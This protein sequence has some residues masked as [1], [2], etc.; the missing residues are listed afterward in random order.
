[1]STRSLIGHR[2]VE[3]LVQQDPRRSAEGALG[4][5]LGTVRASSAAVFH[6][7]KG[8]L[9]LFVS[10]GIGQEDLDSTRRAWARA[11]KRGWSAG[12][13]DESVTLIPLRDGAT[14]AGALYVGSQHRVSVG[15]EVLEVIVPI[16]L[17]A[18]RVSQDP[19][20]QSPVHAYLESTPAEEI[21]RE[22]LFV[23]LNRH[24]WNIAQ[25]ARLLGVS[26][27]TVYHRLAKYGLVRKR[28]EKAASEDAAPG[29]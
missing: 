13:A 29:P 26:R 3:M 11:E 6:V 28:R 5:L 17:A 16:L 23:L 25:V 14:I 12:P 19:T 18:L 4:L 15:A 1:M 21:E 7:R 27:V 8:E 22:Q 24:E 20:L 2:A 9:V 10:R